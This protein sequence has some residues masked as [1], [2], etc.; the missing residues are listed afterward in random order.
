[1]KI[2]LRPSW[3]LTDEHS[4]AAKG[5]AVLVDLEFWEVYHREDMIGAVSA[6]QI[7]SQAIEEMG[8][9]VFLP[10][11]IHFISRF[12]EGDHESQPVPADH[13]GNM[14]KVTYEEIEFLR[15]G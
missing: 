9:N 8:E 15:R 10:E 3:V 2:Y 1:M 6:L 12:K 13:M 4:M 5:K 7:V 11:E 14:K